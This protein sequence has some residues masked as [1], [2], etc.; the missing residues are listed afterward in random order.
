LL[1]AGCGNGSNGGPQPLTAE[2]FAARNG[3]SIDDRSTGQ[4]VDIGG[5]LPAYDSDSERIRVPAAPVSS[6]PQV[7]R[8]T[9]IRPAIQQGVAELTPQPTTQTSAAPLRIDVAAAPRT[10]PVGAA[11]NPAL[12]DGVWLSVGSVVMEVNSHPIYSHKVLQS[13]ERALATEA[14]RVDA[15]QFRQV[16]AEMIARQVEVL[17]RSEL[18]VAAAE[19]ALTAADKQLAD[20]LTVNWRQKQITAAGGSVEMARRKARDDGQDFEEMVAERRRFFLVQIYYQKHV[21]G[22]VSATANEMREYYE[23]NREKEFTTYARTKFRVIKIDPVKQRFTSRD[24]AVTFAEKVRERAVAGEDFGKLAAE[25][26]QDGSDGRVGTAKSNYWLDKGNYSY[27]SL[28]N[29]VR[30]VKPGEV[31]PVIMEKGLYL[32]GKLEDLQ[33]AKVKSFDDPEVQESI[34]TKLRG[35]Q[36][37]AI[38]ERRIRQLERESVTQYKAGQLEEMLETAMR[39]YPEWAGQKA[40]ATP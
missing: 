33:E 20:N 2:G 25:V 23:R 8:P 28:E 10:Q 24:E 34:S 38:R 21:Y 12:A 29:A 14:R 4:P 6:D 3:V 15:R 26:M 16:A 18:E 9:G 22:N 17:K 27:E 19:K 13:L 36:I 1:V 32:I 5:V 39:R 31:T 40:S 37:Q 35:Q 11:T 7:Q 30:A